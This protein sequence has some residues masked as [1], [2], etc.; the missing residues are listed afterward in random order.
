MLL[1]LLAAAVAFLLAGRNGR[2]SLNEVDDN[3]KGIESLAVLPFANAGPD[4]S[5]EYLSDGSTMSLIDAL[6]E[7]DPAGLRVLSWTAVS[8]YKGRDPNPEAI[9]ADLKVQ[10]VLIGRV[11]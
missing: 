8:R 2:R 1:V 6:A 10:A 11:L 4:A 3:A 7:L 5:T 9:G